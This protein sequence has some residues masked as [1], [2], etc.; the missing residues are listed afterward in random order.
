MVEPSFA[1]RSVINHL[2]YIPS[3]HIIA[4]AATDITENEVLTAQGRLIAYDYLVIAT[5]HGD[6]GP[7]SKDEKLSCY[8]AGKTGT[9]MRANLIL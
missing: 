9:N 6:A 3:A 7:C 1:Q 5:G 8:Q 4:S 2:E